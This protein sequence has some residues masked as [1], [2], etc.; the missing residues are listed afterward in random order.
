MSNIFLEVRIVLSGKEKARGDADLANMGSEDQKVGATTEP[1]NLRGKLRENT[2]FEFVGEYLWLDF[3]NTEL[4]KRDRV[5]ELLGDAGDLMYWLRESGVV[6]SEESK[7]A[8]ERLGSTAEG[9]RL[10]E[11]S[12][13]FRKIL[14]ETSERF[15]ED[16]SVSPGL[17]EKINDLLVKRRGHHELSRT[18]EGFEMRFHTLSTLSD[19]PEVL[20]APVAESVARFLADADPSLVKNCENPGCI[21]F[22]Y[23]TSK[24]H[25]RR[26]CSMSTCGNRMKARTHYERAQGRAREDRGKSND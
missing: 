4:V 14:R 1:T 11:R 22:F 3:V 16:G 13:R 24:N 2:G 19:D 9:A 7:A 5:V 8:L 17:V 26:W 25:T 15:G 21:L 18:Q 20:L 12:K 6:S 23:D 10:L